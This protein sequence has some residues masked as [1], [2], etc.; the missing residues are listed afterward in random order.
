MHARRSTGFERSVNCFFEQDAPIENWKK[1][2]QQSRGPKTLMRRESLG[3]ICVKLSLKL[4]VVIL[5]T[6]VS[7]QALWAQ[8]TG[9]AGVLAA[10]EGQETPPVASTAGADDIVVT[11]RRREESLSKVPL[12]VSALGSDQLAKRT[13]V[14]TLDLQSAV[15]GLTIRQNGGSN[16][17]NYAIRG[18]TIDTYTNSPPGVLAYVNEAQIVTHSA[19]VFYDLKGIQVLKGPQGT[20]F[21]RNTTGGAVLYQTAP[22]SDEFGGYITARYANRNAHHIEGALNVPIASGIKLRLAASNSGGGAYV[23]DL[24]ARESYGNLEQSSVRGTLALDLSSRLTNSTMVQYTRDGGTNT[25]G[26]A[27]TAYAC[28]SVPSG[29]PGSCAYGPSNPAFAAYVAAN[30]GLFPGGAVA[31]TAYQNQLG[32]YRSN[33][34]LRPEHNAES[35]IAINTTTFEVSPTLTIKNIFSYSR[36]TAQDIYDF[37]GTPYPIFS[38]VSDAYTSTNGLSDRGYNKYTKQVANELQLQGRGFDGK[39]TF[40]LGAYYLRQTDRINTNLSAFS[41]APL[42]APSVFAYRQELNDESI[43]GFAQATF[44]L[45]NRLNLTGGFR[46]TNDKLTSDQLPGSAWLALVGTGGVVS[47]QRRSDTKP[48]WTASLDY[49]VTP[50]LIAYVTTRGSWRGGGF[51]NT[52]APVNAGAA[53]GGNVFEPETT[54][55]V[56]LGAKYSGTDL[57]VPVNVSVAVYEQWVN[58]IQRALYQTGLNNTVTLLTANVPEARIKGVEADVS[59]RAAPWLR[60]GGAFTYTD[61]KFS[62]PNVVLGGTTYRYGPYADVPKVSGSV[63]FEVTHRLGSDGGELSLRADVYAQSNM[64]FSNTAATISPGTSLPGYTLANGRLSWDRATGS[65]SLALF[66]RNLL[67]EKY[68]AGGN[69]TGYNLGINVANPGQPRTF[70]VEARVGF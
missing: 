62:K 47:F 63:F 55:D 23:Y 50:N 12:S 30:P 3:R 27:Y 11:A 70:G 4:S 16:T 56:E 39:L 20:L 41:F 36:S 9:T 34:S 32:P 17:F 43:A 40:V 67:D 61:A 38:S 24:I 64:Y 25:P 44:E 28:G 31:Y 65:L 26:L 22:A 14:S 59:V 45:T 6:G 69:S 52:V 48:S 42:S 8:T 7:P 5:L 19:S 68:F 33:T 15:P 57:G 10:G 54:K 49:K 37:D 1:W 53:Q 21:G 66:V 13:I 18:Q 29:P 2:R 60:L 51:N 58:N 46:Y 35:L